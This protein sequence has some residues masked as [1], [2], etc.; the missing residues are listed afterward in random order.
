MNCW[1]YGCLP[2]PGMLECKT[3]FGKTWF[4][5]S[6]MFQCF[7][8]YAEQ[9]ISLLI[10]LFQGQNDVKEIHWHRQ[11]SGVLINT[12]ESGFNIFKTISFAFFVVF[13]EMRHFLQLL[14]AKLIRTQK[15]GSLLETLQVFSKE[16]QLFSKELQ[17]K[18]HF[19]KTAKNH[20]FDQ[21]LQ[22]FEQTT[23]FLRLDQLILLFPLRRIW[24]ISQNTDKLSYN[25]K[26]LSARWQ[27]RT[28]MS[29]KCTIHSDD[30]SLVGRN[31]KCS[32][33]I[34]HNRAHWKVRFQPLLN[35]QG[36]SESGAYMNSEKRKIYIY[37]Q[38]NAL[39]EW[40]IGIYL[41]EFTNN[42]REI[43]IPQE[44]AEGGIEKFRVHC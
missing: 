38:V 5:D 15:H 44:A 37:L 40:I 22:L 43:S 7:Q 29:A 14:A 42:E 33:E 26:H 36:N 30:T 21:N 24:N 4:M 1:S 20:R 41:H 17:K 8:A 3:L 34:A 39:R 23:M 10:L 19:V 18:S 32:S 9:R 35:T 11:L 6:P 12:V 28:F 13:H 2:D 27:R 31:R 16:L 25:F